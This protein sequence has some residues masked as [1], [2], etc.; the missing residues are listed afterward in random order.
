M[1]DPVVEL[2]RATQNLGIAYN[3]YQGSSFCKQFAVKADLTGLDPAQIT[4]RQALLRMLGQLIDTEFGEKMDALCSA[5]QS[6][7]KVSNG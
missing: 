6:Y 5:W 2:Q 1:P 7:R 4:A 3:A